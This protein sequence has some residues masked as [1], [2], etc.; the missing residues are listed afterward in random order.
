[1]QRGYIDSVGLLTLALGMN[2]CGFL[3]KAQ[4]LAVDLVRVQ[5]AVSKEVGPYATGIKIVNG[6]YLDVSVANSPW[7]DGAENEK[8][9]EALKIAR[10]AY[11][12]YSAR[13]DLRQ[14]SV[15]F[16][17][18]RTY[19]LFINYDDSRDSYRFDVSELNP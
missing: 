13:R 15:T 4:D 3:H 9:P 5:L 1:M 7:H 11:R 10:I 16:A 19:L 18:H 6:S 12:S 14:V 8:Y 2:A 17:V